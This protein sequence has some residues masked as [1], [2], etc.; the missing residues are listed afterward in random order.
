VYV[1]YVVKKGSRLRL[2]LAN[3]DSLV[4]DPIFSHTDTPDKM[5]EDTIHHS[6]ARPSRLVLTVA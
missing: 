1:G 6:R 3:G 2:E 4:A 5:G